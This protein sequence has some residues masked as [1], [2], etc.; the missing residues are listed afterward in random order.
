MKKMKLRDLKRS[1]FLAALLSGVCLAP[2]AVAAEGAQSG[3]DFISWRGP[4]GTGNF[5][6][7]A[8]PREWSDG[9]QVR[10]R[11][12]LPGRGASSPIVVGDQIFVTSSD[13][14]N[15]VLSCLDTSGKVLWT[16][17]FGEAAQAKN[18][19]ATAANSSPVSDGKHVYAY[20]KSG[21]LVCCG[22]DGSLKWSINVQDRY[23]ENTLWWDLGT[24]PVLTDDS[25]IVAVVQS[26]PSFVLSLDKSNGSEQWRTDRMLNA[27]EESNQAYTTPAVYRDGDRTL[28]LTLGADHLTAHDADTGKEVFRVGGFNPTNHQYYRSIASPVVVGDLAICPYARGETL[29]AIRLGKDIPEGERV[30][31]R[32]EDLGTDVP[33]PAV[34]GDRLFVCGDKGR[35]ACLSAKDGET[36]WEQQLP[37]HRRVYS[38][39]P[40]VGGGLLYCTR[41]D[42]TTFVLDVESG[43]V[44]AENKVEGETVA[45]PLPDDGRLYIRTY[46]ALVCVGE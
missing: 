35:V 32:R 6:D 44:V 20:F 46:D 18:Q 41:E 1:L 38:S 39:S 25:V 19:K 12:E 9:Q 3:G 16:K 21:E 31:W 4:S 22:L 34:L 17:R 42:A 45:T 5:G 27:N 30:A 37:K 15:N 7:A 8:L 26:G 29:T 36:I 14:Q 40:V 43:E 24:S 2:S 28:V 33:T 10:W 23:A 13:E 11:T